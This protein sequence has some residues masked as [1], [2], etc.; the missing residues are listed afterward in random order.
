MEFFRRSST[1]GVTR[2]VQAVLHIDEI[3]QGVHLAKF[4]FAG[5]RRI[6][7]PIHFIVVPRQHVMQLKPIQMALLHD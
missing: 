2:I 5:R 7:C 6:P 4:S 1:Q 3:D